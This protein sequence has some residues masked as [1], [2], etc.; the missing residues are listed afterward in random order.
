MKTSKILALIFVIVLPVLSLA[1]FVTVSGIKFLVDGKEI[2][3]NGANTPWN[4]WN[5]F[6]GNYT[7]SWW[8]AEFQKIKAAG[9]NST[10]IWI[11]CNGEVGLMI[12]ADG[13]VTGATTAFWSNLD[14]MFRLARSI[15]LRTATPITNAGEIWFSAMIR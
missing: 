14:D 7:S 10:R 9:G 2:I 12:S 15:I 3:M 13:M 6:G 11:S 4:K 8:D 5:D 1:Q